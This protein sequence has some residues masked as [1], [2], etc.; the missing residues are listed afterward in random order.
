MLMF[1]DPQH[2]ELCRGLKILYCLNIIFF[3]REFMNTKHLQEEYP[4]R[5]TLITCHSNADFDA[6]ASLMGASLL[7]PDAYL[8]FPGTQEKMVQELYDDVAQHFFSF[9]AIKSID[10]AEVER[11]VVL[12]TQSMDRVSHIKPLLRAHNL[13]ENG[14]ST[15]L[16]GNNTKSDHNSA[17]EVL[18][19]DHHPVSDLI[20]QGGRCANVGSTCTLI[21]AELKRVFGTIPCEIANILALG[22]YVDTGS[23]VYSST[24]AEDLQITAW[25]LGQGFIPDFVVPYTQRS[26]N[27][28]QF[29]LL[30]ALLESA[31]FM[32]M[33]GI[34]FIVAS[35]RIDTYLNDFATLAPIFME[36]NPCHVLFALAAMGDKIQIVARS[37]HEDVD[38]GKICEL[39]GGGG[40]AYAAS[41]MVKDKTLHELIS[42]L[43]TQ[44]SLLG[45]TDKKANKL[46]SSPVVAV[47][48]DDLMH[49]A[50][51][52]MSQYGLK[53][54]PVYKQ[55]TQ[56]CVGWLEHQLAIKAISHGLNTVR[57]SAY[58]QRNFQ[59]VSMDADL[60]MLMDI[61]V[62]ERQRLVPVV[63]ITKYE[64]FDYGILLKNVTN[65]HDNI[66]LKQ[67]PVVGVVS[68]TD[69]IHIFL[70]DGKIQLPQPKQKGHRKR[71]VTKILRMRT[72]SQCIQLLEIAGDL[73]REFEMQVYVVGG[74][75][76]DLLMERG[77]L[78]WP[79]MDI[80][81]VVEGDGIFFAKQL[82]EK[83]NGR[84]REHAAFMTALVIFDNSILTQ[85]ATE[86]VKSIELRVDVATARLEYYQSPAALPTVELSSIRMDLT[87]RDFSINA[88]A[89]HLNAPH[90]GEL[91]DFFDG[92]GDINQKRIRMLHALSF[93]EDPTRALRAVRFEQR[94]NFKIGQ[95]CERFIRD[96]VELEL[97]AKLDGKRVLT[98]FEIILKENDPF[99]CLVRLD[100]FHLLEAIHPLLA[101]SEGTFAHECYKM[102]DWY[103][104]LYLEEEVNLFFFFMFAT[105]KNASVVDI[106]NIFER[107][108]IMESKTQEFL[109]LRSSLIHVIVQLEMKSDI[110]MSTLH[111]ILRVLPI[112]VLLFL[113]VR[114]QAIAGEVLQ[115]Q[116]THYI[117]S[118]RQ[119]RIEIRGTDILE[120]GM[121]SGPLVGAILQ[122]VLHA[123]LDGFV[124]GYDEEMDFAQQRVQHYHNLRAHEN[125]MPLKRK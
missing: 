48:E 105:C 7:F 124:M 119:E 103:R 106:E 94:Y 22:I 45:Y 23:F 30:N 24:T 12:D 64:G 110:P 17:L 28:E 99:S 47:Y 53:A 46:M 76:R 112:E 58:M 54:I 25:L 93:V 26:L 101:L 121:E 34:R 37:K 32:N 16:D 85:D 84:V 116:I 44:I 118:S 117:Y 63:D 51:K 92:Q 89:I 8:V 78:R 43:Q 9:V 61:I 96:A 4:A 42:Y 40:H 73:G 39:F 87:R 1:L 111:G 41:A 13:L 20:A 55:N 6:L 14:I 109:Q 18:I 95:Q 31:E 97:I 29:S 83:L 71:N 91:V 52:I 59:V 108:G 3:T 74:F 122:E 72:H 60:Q 35:A 75:V 120:L 123:K 5:K 67:C 2:N 90:F 27:K 114:A 57:V 81:L 33:G 107:F 10:Y 49:N 69:L 115:K 79:H 80:D 38:V 56:I 21:A 86:E 11:L 19:W 65:S 77:K 68:R 62:G 70:E 100:E 50:E 82:A 98:E 15:S 113:V 66:Q 102:L 88:M 104:L 36:M 125:G